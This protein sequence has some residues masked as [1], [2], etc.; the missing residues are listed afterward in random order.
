[1]YTLTDNTYILD[2][3]GNKH[4]VS[5]KDRYSIDKSFLVTILKN[6]R[7][8]DC[9]T[10]TKLYSLTV[11]AEIEVRVLCPIFDIKIC[12][13]LNLRKEKALSLFKACF[14]EDALFEELL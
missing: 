9:I 4:V 14:G 11:S 7:C 3:Q 13:N 12:D 10:Q 2:T 8:G 1:M 6:K 5:K